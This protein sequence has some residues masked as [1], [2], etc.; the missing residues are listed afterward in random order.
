MRYFKVFFVTFL[1][2]ILLSC[3]TLLTDKKAASVSITTDCPNYTGAFDCPA[4]PNLKHP[5]PAYIVYGAAANKNGIYTYQSQLSISPN[6]KS[7][8]V[9]DNNERRS[10]DHK[11][12]IRNYRAECKKGVLINRYSTA[13]GIAQTE[14]WIDKDGHLKIRYDFAKGKI[15][16]C[17][18]VSG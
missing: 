5:Q 16:T 10:K 7:T 11:G 18:R 4:M 1:S 6:I 17:K 3:T 9:A 12:K 8:I 13:S 14:T 15:L 2:V